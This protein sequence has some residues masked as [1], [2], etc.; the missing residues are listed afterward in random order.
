M[1][2]DKKIF[3]ILKQR[4]FLPLFLTQF[5]GAFNDNAF[6]LS[7]LTLISYGLSKSQVESEYFQVLAGGIFI[8]PFFIF[9]ATAGQ[10]A[11][12]FDKSVLT[13][14][15]KIFELG[16]IIIGSLAIWKHSIFFMMLTL[17]FLGIHSTFFGPIKYA[18]LPDLLP[19]HQLMFATALIEASTFVAILLG[20]TFGALTI[21]TSDHIINTKYSIIMVVIVSISGLI[22]SLFIPKAPGNSRVKIDWKLWHATYFMLLSI[23]HHKKT[24]PVVGVISWFWMMGAITL[25]K[26]PDYTHYVLAVNTTVLAIFLTLFSLGIALGSLTIGYWLKDQI[27]LKYVSLTMI[28]VSLFIMDFSYASPEQHFIDNN[29]LQTVGQFISSIRSWRIMFDFFMF[30]FCSGLFI[31][32]LY[33]HLQVCG[34][35]GKRARLIASN[36]ILNALGMVFGTLLVMLLLKLNMSIAGVFFIIALLNVGVAIIFLFLQNMVQVD[37]TAY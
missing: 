11:D 2:L 16:I 34:Q 26:L 25:T 13:L 10:L 32:P 22:S 37:A 28:L 6:K 27:T 14:L 30:S 7:M 3:N 17:M 4:N 33:T 21:E 12:K 5:F 36:N 15:V 1:N 29:T 19:R 23:F 9:S 35:D 18:I 8:L 24:Y 20:T 31:V